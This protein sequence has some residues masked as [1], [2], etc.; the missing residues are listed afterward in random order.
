VLGYV[1]DALSYFGLFAVTAMVATYALEARSHW[2]VLLFA[3]SCGLASIYGFLQDAWPF[4]VLA[5]IGAIFALR[6]WQ[7]RPRLL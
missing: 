3:A 4:G 6:R 2:F 5:A 7:N 1:M